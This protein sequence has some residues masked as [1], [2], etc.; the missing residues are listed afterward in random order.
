MLCGWSNLGYSHAWLQ[1]VA[2]LVATR[3]IEAV[4]RVPKTCS[5]YPES[6]LGKNMRKLMSRFAITALVIGLASIAH[7]EVGQVAVTQSANSSQAM[8]VE[9]W[10]RDEE[11]HR[12]LVGQQVTHGEPVTFGRE[13]SYLVATPPGTSRD[14]YD[15]HWSMTIRDIHS[16]VADSIAFTVSM[17]GKD[18]GAWDG[19]ATLH[20][21]TGTGSRTGAVHWLDGKDY[22]I[23]LHPLAS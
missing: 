14:E 7:A 18:P 2:N 13:F 23:T 1:L 4:G 6:Q 21:E 3:L 12:T 16:T 19:Q 15:G 8:S 17:E 10:S 9:V 20:V 11:G 5:S 22:V